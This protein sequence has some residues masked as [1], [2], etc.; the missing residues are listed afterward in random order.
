[1][2]LFRQPRPV[3]AVAFACV[4]AFMGIGLVDPILKPIADDLGA[5]PAQVSLLFTSYMAVMGMTML[6]TGWVSSRLGAKRTLILGLAI[7]II[8]AG[9]AGSM[10]SIGGIV[11][12]RAVWGLGNALFIAT[13][14]ATIVASARGSVGQAIILYEAALGLGIAAGPLLGGALGGISWRYPF[15]GVS[16]LMA[17]ALVA[18]VFSLPSTPPAAQ[19]SSISAPLRALARHRNLLAVGLTAMA[20][21]FGFFTLLAFTPF[22]LAMDAR[23]IGL[24]FFGWG[25]MLAITSVVVA[26]MIQRRFGTASGI[27]GALAAFTVI[28]V[29]MGI[30]TDSKPVL[31]TCVVLAGAALGVNNTL[32]T[33]TVVKV[34]PVERGVASAAYSFVRFSGGAVAPWLAGT[35]GERSAHLP[36]FV[37]AGAV[38]IAALIFFTVRGAVR[39]IDAQPG[40]GAEPIASEL[41]AEAVTAGA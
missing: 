21:N 15:Y 2:S 4:I 40:H 8:G 16:V 32:I 41:E 22:P 19:R 7:I 12:F 28:L 14:L 30:W 18:T 26:P 24:V 20:Y 33:E 17:I 27:L 11:G 1:M 39:A 13:A 10:D 37:G 3:L 31:V 29:A 5:G 23:G 9:L 34:A 25:A 6:V 36:F 35:L 38:V